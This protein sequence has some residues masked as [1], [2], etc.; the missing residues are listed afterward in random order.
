MIKS[1]KAQG[2]TLT[3]VLIAVSIISLAILAVFSVLPN[4]ANSTQ[5]LSMKTKAASISK[6]V[7]I[8]VEEL[9]RDNRASFLSGDYKGGPSERFKVPVSGGGETKFTIWGLSNTGKKLT[10]G[11]KPTA[12]DFDVKV[13]VYPKQGGDGRFKNY[14]IRIETLW[15]ASKNKS[16]QTRYNGKEEYF[17]LVSPI[18]PY[19]YD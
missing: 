5:D 17:Q 14:H 7:A 8:D 4:A 6:A 2:F 9:I 12:N 16:A 13:F 11:Q 10:D 18:I 1:H 3:E 15:P 19:N